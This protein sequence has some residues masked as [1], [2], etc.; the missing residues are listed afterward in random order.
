MIA[1]GYTDDAKRDTIDA[2]CRR[3]GIAHV[4]AISTDAFPLA[5]EGADHVPYSEVIMYRTFYRLLQEISGATLVVVNECL[6]NQN[7]YDLAYNCIRNFLNQ[8]PHVLVFQQLPQIDTYEDFMILFD[9]ATQSR[10]KRQ[11][12]DRDLIAANAEVDVRPLALTFERVDVP[13]S[14]ATKAHY[15]TERATLFAALGP[16][17]PH[18]LPRNLYLLGGK[19]KAAYISRQSSNTLFSTGQAA[20]YVARNKRL[21]L[22]CVVTYDDVTPAGAPYTVVEFPHAFADWC[23]FLRRTWQA[24]TPVL[25][26]DL[27]VD[28]WYWQRYNDWMERVHA[29]YASL[30][31]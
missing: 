22:E 3:H 10:W 6:H 4:V 25:V 17:D 16:R 7:R 5:L 28:A 15:D 19:D 23:D 1:L 14:A 24:V 13:T 20:H 18:T 31:R 8:T 29:T 2:Y 12:F 11:R 27:K 21:G 26:A 30:R 9:F